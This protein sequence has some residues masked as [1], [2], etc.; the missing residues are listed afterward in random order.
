[1]L[2]IGIILCGTVIGGG[3]QY[4]SDRRA[5][6]RDWTMA[7]IAGFLGASVGGL[8][9]SLLSGDGISFGPSGIIGSLAGAVLVT[10]ALRWWRTRDTNPA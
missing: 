10:V 5:P 1:M 9:L 8:L 3:A 4:I 7:L 6:T 2:V